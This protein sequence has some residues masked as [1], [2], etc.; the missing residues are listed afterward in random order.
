MNWCSVVIPK[1]LLPKVNLSELIVHRTP[2]LYLE[3]YHKACRSLTDASVAAFMAEYSLF[4]ENMKKKNYQSPEV[5]VSTMESF[6]LLATS[7]KGNITNEHAT[8][9]AMGNTSNMDMETETD[10][11]EEV[12]GIKRNLWEN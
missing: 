3:T 1:V 11:Q 10:T 5:Y 7:P 6:G 12:W 2:W 9:P 8:G 4:R